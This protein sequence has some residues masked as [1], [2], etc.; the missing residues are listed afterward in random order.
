MGTMTQHLYYQTS[1][2]RTTPSGVISPMSPEWNLNTAARYGPLKQR[3]GSTSKA[4]CQPSLSKSAASLDLWKKTWCKNTQKNTYKHIK[5]QHLIN[6]LHVDQHLK[7]TSE[8]LAKPKPSFLQ[9]SS[10][11]CCLL[12]QLVVARTDGITWPQGVLPSTIHSTLQSCS[13]LLFLLHVASKPSSTIFSVLSVCVLSLSRCFLQLPILVPPLIQISP[14][15]QQ[16]E[17][18]ECTYQEASSA[19]GILLNPTAMN[20]PS[21]AHFGA[22]P[23][24]HHPSDLSSAQN[25][26]LVGL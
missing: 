12:W 24:K 20:S 5:I 6:M 21:I 2:S 16:A 19:T 7:H 22:R 9:L 10:P 25:L 1:G 15:P 17:P 13:V 18:S 4:L 14:R 8:K 26:S 11:S 3:K 23:S